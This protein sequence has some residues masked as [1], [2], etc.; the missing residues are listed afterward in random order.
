MITASTDDEGVSD[1]L[2]NTLATTI[3]ALASAPEDSEDAL[4]YTLLQRALREWE[5]GDV[6]GEAVGEQGDSA[7][8]LL[9][10]TRALSA[11]KALLAPDVGG[12]TKE[13]LQAAIDRFHQPDGEELPAAQLILGAP[14][15]SGLHLR[16]LPENEP[17]STGDPDPEHRFVQVDFELKAE[18]PVSCWCVPLPRRVAIRPCTSTN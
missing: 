11:L 7:N 13:D 5:L 3:D 16:L 12:L 15:G 10:Q 2:T 17:G 9:A 8:Q 14:D 4:L 1:A 6:P 18:P